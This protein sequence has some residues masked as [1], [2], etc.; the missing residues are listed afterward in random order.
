[1]A[2]AN[3]YADF[4]H[5]GF[6][7]QEGFW[8]SKESN[9]RVVASTPKCRVVPSVTLGTGVINSPVFAA[10]RSCGRTVLSCGPAKVEFLFLAILSRANR[11]KPLANNI[12]AGMSSQKPQVDPPGPYL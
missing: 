1:M 5:A 10:G 7:N 8:F 11:E 3:R 12:A 9:F 4:C 2:D 6:G